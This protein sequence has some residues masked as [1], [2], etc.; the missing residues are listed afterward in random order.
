MTWPFQIRPT[1]K[2]EVRGGGEVT[3][4]ATGNTLTVTVPVLN[5]NFRLFR[6]GE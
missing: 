4:K 3:A 5:R 1:A 2:P 6:V